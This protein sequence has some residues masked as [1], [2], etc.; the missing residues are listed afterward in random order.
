MA[1]SDSQE[2]TGTRALALAWERQDVDFFFKCSDLQFIVIYTPV[3]WVTVW[4]LAQWQF[5]DAGLALYTLDGHWLYL[6]QGV[7]D[8]GI[9][10]LQPGEPFKEW[11]KGKCSDAITRITLLL[12]DERGSLD[13]PGVSRGAKPPADAGLPK[14]QKLCKTWSQPT[15]DTVNANQKWVFLIHSEASTGSSHT[16]RPVQPP[17]NPGSGMILVIVLLPLHT[18]SPLSSNSQGHCKPLP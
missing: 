16:R 11:G 12:G 8:W 7:S 18:D 5:R 13:I 4:C 9:A 6:I 10:M 15:S 1:I 14:P 3:Q 17:F 2:P